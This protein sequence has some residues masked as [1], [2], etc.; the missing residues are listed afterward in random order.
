[1]GINYTNIPS[2][3]RN[4]S[5]HTA[6]TEGIP[7]NQAVPTNSSDVV[8]H[9]QA[10]ILRD[11]DIVPF[12]P[13][14]IVLPDDYWLKGSFS[15]FEAEVVAGMYVALS[16]R[17]DQ[18]WVSVG[19]AAFL[20]LA[21]EDLL[22]GPGV[23]FTPETHPTFLVDAQA[24]RQFVSDGIKRLVQ[25]GVLMVDTSGPLKSIFIPGRRMFEALRNHIVTFPN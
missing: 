14:D 10:F 25:D 19:Y 24:N 13:H 7:M 4:T 9:E 20:N 15:S 11:A 8:V 12:R 5:F 23:E 21:R 16:R 1:M 18:D 17:V 2:I 6:R 3:S 22:G